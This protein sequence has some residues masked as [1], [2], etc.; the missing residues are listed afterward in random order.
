M[1]EALVKENVGMMPYPEA[2]IFVEETD[3]NV[4]C[5]EMLSAPPWRNPDAVR[6]VEETAASDD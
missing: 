2:V 5:P 6:L 1:P 3:A 4:D